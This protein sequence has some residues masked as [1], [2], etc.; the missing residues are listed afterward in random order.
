MNII[1]IGARGAGKSKV[2]RSL[3][4]KT[5]FPVVSTDSTA[6]YEAGGISI[7]SF[8]E[9]YDWKKFRELEY[10]ILQ[11]L[12]NANGI[13]LDCGGGILFDLDESG[14]EI[15]S[16]RKLDILRKIG[17]IVY[18]ERDLEELIEKVKGD[19][20]RPDLSKV[21]SYRSI[22]E[23]RL[24]VYQE[25]AHFKLNLSKLTKEEA[26]ERVLDWLGIKSK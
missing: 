22:L 19:S 20:T 7:P 11:K 8:V 1:F 26:A 15:P 17:R 4:K 14:N 21:N 12:E 24:P 3:S 13:I 5:D 9:K 16:R 2:S 10:S 23:K 25:A 18:L 6:V